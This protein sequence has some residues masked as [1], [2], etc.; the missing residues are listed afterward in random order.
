MARSPCGGSHD[1]LDQEMEML[2]NAAG[3]KTVHAYSC[4]RNQVQNDAEFDI[5]PAVSISHPLYVVYELVTLR[6]TNYWSTL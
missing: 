4:G 6:Q 1:H 2:S 3:A 5:L